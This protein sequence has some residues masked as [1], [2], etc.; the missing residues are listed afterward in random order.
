[1]IRKSIG[2]LF[3]GLTLLMFPTLFPERFHQNG[4]TVGIYVVLIFLGTVLC[5]Y[6]LSKLS[7]VN[8]LWI[9]IF[10]ALIEIGIYGSFYFVKNGFVES[11]SIIIRYRNFYE[12]ML[13]S[14]PVYQNALGRY[15]DKLFYTLKPGK[16]INS[17]IEFSNEYNIN[18]QGLRDDESSLDFPEIIV[19]GD[20]HTMGWGVNQDETYANL[21][22]KQ[23]GKKVLNAG[24]VSYGTARE[25]LM[26]KRLQLDSCKL[27]VIQYCTNDA[28][29]NKEFV[30]N[31]F[32]LDISSE[33]V[34]KSA[35]WEDFLHRNY[36]PF[37]FL[38]EGTAHQIKKLLFESKY[39]NKTK[40]SI[41]EQAYNFF[42]IMDEI[43]KTYKGE[44]LI[45]NLESHQTRDDVFKEFAK[46]L[47]QIGLEN[48]HVLNMS[49][50]ISHTGYYVIDGHPNKKGHLQIATF[51]E[52]KMKK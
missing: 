36:Y 10:S 15:D 48:F 47:N 18:S 19:L 49:L 16:G 11:T 50:A 35:C 6:F 23:T 20:S 24:I 30:E 39:A 2:W 25:F 5:V 42:K 17:N 41:E 33:K 44:V 38:F 40:I 34:Y 12:G 28:S 43:Q 1:M 9:L 29:E 14:V 52:S 4:F 32:K 46:R 27:L 51:I 45:F 37:K 31:D 21:L 7:R 8:I 22:E 13:R 26:L 3:L